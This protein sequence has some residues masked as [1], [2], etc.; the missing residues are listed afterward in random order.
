M[1]SA[2]LIPNSAAKSPAGD[3]ASSMFTPTTISPASRY[4]SCSRIRTGISRRQGAHHDAQKFST[5][6]CPAQSD[7]RK[8]PPSSVSSSKSGASRPMA[9]SGGRAASGRSGGS[10]YAGRGRR[11]EVARPAAAGP[12]P[13]PSVS[14]SGIATAASTS[15]A[16]TSVR[17]PWYSRG[18]VGCSSG[19][20][21]PLLI[22]AVLPHDSTAGSRCRGPPRRPV[23]MRRQPQAASPAILAAL[24]GAPDDDRR[25]V[26]PPPRRS[27]RPCS[28]PGCRTSSPCPTRT[29]ARS[30][31]RSRRTPSCA[32]SR[33]RPRTRRR[34][35]APA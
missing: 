16:T 31:R 2:K 4:C 27:C 29:S 19:K 11:A 7:S 28:T 15:T 3:R 14:Q 24:E 35:S 25:R 21:A 32:S 30:S 22:G 1:G 20:L 12:P 5:T 34:P 8:R 17:A 13:F 6:G 26:D 18:R 9:S 23:A 10:R 33:P